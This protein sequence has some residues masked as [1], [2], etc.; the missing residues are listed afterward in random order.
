[1][2]ITIIFALFFTFNLNAQNI[3][4]RSSQV[5]GDIYHLGGA[6]GI[7]TNAPDSSSLLD[8]YSRQK[9]IL[10]P[11]LSSQQIV[12]IENPANSLIVFNSTDNMFMFFDARSS[13]WKS[14]IS[15]DAVC[16]GDM[17][18]NRTDAKEGVTFLSNINDKVGIGTNTP[19]ASLEIKPVND[20]ALRILTSETGISA[21]IQFTDKN[22]SNYVGFIA[23]ENVD[24]NILWQL[25]AVKGD[26]GQV[27]TTNGEGILAW[28]NKGGPYDLWYRNE[29]EY[30]TYLTNQEDNVL[31]GKSGEQIAYKQLHLIKD[32][33]KADIYPT[34]RLE[35]IETGNKYQVRDIEN[36]ETGLFFKYG[37]DKNENPEMT[38]LFSVGNT[39]NIGIGTETSNKAIEIFKFHEINE[40]KDN[41]CIRLSDFFEKEGATGAERERYF[42]W[43]IENNKRALKFNYFSHKDIQQPNPKTK[44]TFSSDGTLQAAKFVGDGSGLTNVN[45]LWKKSGNNI[46]YDEGNVIIKGKQLNLIKPITTG[47]WAR[48]IMYYKNENSAIWGGIGLLGSA[49]N[50]SLIYIAHGSTPWNSGKGIYIKTNG[51]VGI[52][53]T[54]PN[55]PLEINN[56]SYGSWSTPFIKIKKPANS[57]LAAIGIET[58]QQNWVIAAINTSTGNEGLWIKNIK[59]DNVPFRIKNNGVVV[60]NGNLW[61]ANE[62]AVQSTDPWPDYVFKK[63][64]RLMPL[65]QLQKFI[66]KNNRLPDMPSSEDIKKDGIKLAENQTL[67]LKKIEELTLYILQLKEENSKLQKQITELKTK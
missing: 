22:E 49:D 33:T 48:G 53:T 32:I 13:T 35:N 5:D 29:E 2:P 24:E 39:G 52:G 3:S 38:T 27:L 59:T 8:I 45:G 10:I 64:Y 19:E 66:Y 6:I 37:E 23:P 14:I 18:W 42:V 62:V 26:S 9:G 4:V 57:D 60:V 56:T 67:M 30:T 1:M 11:R 31:I 58:N 46:Y 25:P 47:G 43:D 50:S 17:L 63:D 16:G 65:E 7:G 54:D 36:S 41:T 21:N 28:E 40:K 20:N 12:S 44:F 15:T 34:I 51:N 61:V 55:T